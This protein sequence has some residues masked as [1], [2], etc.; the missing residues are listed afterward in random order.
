GA[1]NDYMKGYS[2]ND[3]MDGGAGS[4]T[5]YGNDGD[6]V[7]VSGSDNADDIIYGNS[8][9][10]SFYFYAEGEGIGND[11]V[12]DF[13]AADGDQLIIGGQDV[14]FEIIQLAYNR[15][16]VSITNNYG[17]DL[18]AITVRGQLNA[19]DVTIDNDSFD[20]VNTPSVLELA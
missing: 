16:Q 12:H 17:D 20:G 10:D 15:S 2:G 1:G 3:T 7:I 4:D 13:S 18:G 6:D 9:A 11:T 5:I 8:G 19:D 14:S